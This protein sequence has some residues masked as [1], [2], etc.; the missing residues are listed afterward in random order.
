MVAVV[1]GR[2]IDPQ[3][4]RLFPLYVLIS[5][6]QMICREGR[7]ILK[8]FPI[9]QTNTLKYNKVLENEIK[10]ESFKRQAHLKI[11]I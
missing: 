8:K 11:I 6:S 1:A 3:E 7:P 5:P 4:N 9:C 10:R 2:K